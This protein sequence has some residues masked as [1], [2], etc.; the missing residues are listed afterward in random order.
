MGKGPFEVVFLE[1]Y[2]SQQQAEVASVRIGYIR[3]SSKDQNTARQHDLLKKHEVEKIYEEKVSGKSIKNREQLQA[4]LEFA[5]EGDVIVVESISRL[6]RNVL[7]FLTIVQDLEQR[8]ISVVSLKELIDTSTPQGKFAMT[9]F[10]AL[11]ELERES[12]R[13]KQAEGIAS[14]Q[15][16]GVRFG[17]PK[18]EINEEFRRSYA[19]CRAGRITAVAAMKELGISS[20]TF[21]R[22]VS[23]Y[24][25]GYES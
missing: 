24:E 1:L 4:L 19:E 9:V 3:V 21:Y 13:E 15:N 17:R 6:A 22:R 8:G 14:A 16:R 5:R 10:G 7:E 23:E 25:A 18:T 11:Y 2:C 12:I 20:A